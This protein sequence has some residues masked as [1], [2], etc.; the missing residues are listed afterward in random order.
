MSEETKICKVCHMWKNLDDFPIACVK[1]GK[2]YYRGVCKA[3][4]YMAKT[5]Q[6]REYSQNYYKINRNSIIKQSTEYNKTHPE[7]IAAAQHK[8]YEKNKRRIIADMIETVKNDPILRLRANISRSI[9]EALFDVQSSKGGRSFLT[10]IGYTIED[11][12]IHMET[13]FETWM[14][15][16]N[17]G[18]YKT[19]RW[20]DNNT[21]T[22]KWNIDHIIPQADLPY[23]SMEDDN[24]KKCWALTNLRPLSA[25]Q[26]N[27]DGSTRVRHGNQNVL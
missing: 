4:Y 5:E 15:W 11:L 23:I 24:F 19:N 7:T 18:A 16:D 8:Y 20:D 12:K 1:N 6:D 2:T 9:R 26:N 25:K 17:Y 21:T 22:W 10:Y 14:N 27:I 3:C 13:L